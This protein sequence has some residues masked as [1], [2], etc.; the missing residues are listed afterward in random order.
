MLLA[1]LHE[2][3]SAEF[4]LNP[5]E[6]KCPESVGNGRNLLELVCISIGIA[7]SIAIS[8]GRKRYWIVRFW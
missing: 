6:K 1:P 4:W 2:Y 5:S 7:I 8:I 3:G